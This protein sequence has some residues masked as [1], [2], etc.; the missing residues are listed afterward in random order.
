MTAQEIIKQTETLS[1]DEQKNLTIFLLLKYINP[2]EKQK[3]MQLFHYKN[4]FKDF[5]ENTLLS[6]FADWKNKL[7]QD[8]VIN[9]D[10]FYN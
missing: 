2:D 9:D 7:L 4:N 6:N 1:L 3:L 8:L 5:K 10:E